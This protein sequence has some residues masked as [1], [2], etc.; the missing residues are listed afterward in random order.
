MKTLTENSRQRLGYFEGNWHTTG[1]FLSGK[2]E[3][4]NILGF[5]TYEWLPGTHFLMHTVDIKADNSHIR[6]V[7][8]IGW[9]KEM[10]MIL[11]RSFDSDGNYSEYSFVLRGDEILIN[12][13]AMR[14]NGRFT[15]DY[16]RITGIW[17]EMT[18]NG[19]RAIIEVTLTRM[20]GDK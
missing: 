10:K 6:S 20:E 17:E 16:S 13:S 18:V 19:W 14:F 7:E 11:G 4:Q 3:G 9:D 8:I 15:N 2:M 5:D 1:Q 12:G